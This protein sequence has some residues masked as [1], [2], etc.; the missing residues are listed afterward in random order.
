MGNITTASGN[1]STAM[2][3]NT[4]ASGDFTTA[5]GSNASTNSKIG[6]FVLGDHAGTTTLNSGATN[7]FST[8]FSGGYRLYSNSTL[9]AGVILAPGAGAWANVSDKTKKENFQTLQA[10][11]VLLKIKKIPVTQ[12]NYKS[13]NETI[14]HIGP[15]AQD[16][17]LQFKLGG[18]G[19]DTTITTS[20]ID[21]VNM[22]G[23]QALENR[24]SELKEEIIT[25][26]TTINQQEMKV[27]SLESQ[28]LIANELLKKMDRLS[29]RLN[30]LEQVSASTSALNK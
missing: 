16:F 15:M 1:S 22:L 11:E 2:G 25:L 30:K 28:L 14:H 4:T 26:Q 5:M 20:D 3:S 17:Y 21:G 24:T 13:Q 27:A 10:E 19:N 6:S 8:R 18:F 23:I 7:E 12:W 29:D 9:T